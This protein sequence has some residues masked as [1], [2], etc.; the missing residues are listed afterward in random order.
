MIKLQSLKLNDNQFTTIPETIGNL[1]N[2]SLLW[3]SSNQ[4]LRIPQSICNLDPILFEFIEWGFEPFPGSGDIVFESNENLVLGWNPLVECGEQLPDCLVESG[5]SSALVTCIAFLQNDIM[6]FQV[7]GPWGV[8]DV[9]DVC[10]G[11][12]ECGICGGDNACLHLEDILFPDHFSSHSIYP[13]PFNPITN[14]IYG[15]PE[16][17]NVQIIVYDISGKQLETLISEFQTPGYH[18]V[19]W[20]ADNL[21]SGVYL[22][23]MESGEFIETQKV[24]L[25]K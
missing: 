7:C 4:L 8:C 16:H 18:S 2:L 24:V 22:I 13:N 1:E 17:V 12:D 23:R 5:G 21:P 11:Y 9:M 10:E 25:V 19:S 3:I 14:I 15:L 20:N 6:G